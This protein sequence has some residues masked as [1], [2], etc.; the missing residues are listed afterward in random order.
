LVVLVDLTE[1]R[2]LESVRRDFIANASH[3]LR[4]P[5]T[6]IRAAAETLEST[7]DDAGSA[8]R[9]VGLIVRNA[10]RLQSLVDDMLELSR[11][12]SRAV[13][14]EPQALD[15]A[16]VAERV[17]AQHLPLAEKK[18]IRLATELSGLPAVRADRRALEHVL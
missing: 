7:G 13:A 5:L 14:L 11:I 9:F 3:E 17:L 8:Q 16:A 6:S 4:S 12:E 1:L 15:L 18:R 10:E 2:R